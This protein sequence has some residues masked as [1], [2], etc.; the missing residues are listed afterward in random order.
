MAKEKRR[1][2]LTVRSQAK[3]VSNRLGVVFLIVLLAFV[4]LSARL[5]YITKENNNDYQH[6][7]LSQQA[8]DS[9]VINAKRGEIV[10]RNGTVL[11]TSKES[12]NVILDVKNSPASFMLALFT[13]E[14]FS[15]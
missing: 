8:Y 13:C 1:R 2:K 12:Y 3:I 6:K 7:I 14:I 11:A 10:D 9:Q 15:K 4:G 5:I